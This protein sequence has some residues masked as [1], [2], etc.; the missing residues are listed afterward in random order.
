[1]VGVVDERLVAQSCLLRSRPHEDQAR[2]VER[3]CGRL[4]DGHP[5]NDDARVARRAAALALRQGR[6]SGG[7]RI[8]RTNCGRGTRHLARSKRCRSVCRV[9]HRIAHA[10]DS[11]VSSCV[12][13]R[14]SS[15]AKSMHVDET[16]D[17][18]RK[19]DSCPRFNLP[20]FWHPAAH[21]LSSRA[22]FR[23]P[24]GV[25]FVLRWKPAAFVEPIPPSSTPPFQACRSRS[26]PAM[27]LRAASARSAT[28]WRVGQRANASRLVGSEVTVA[29]RPLPRG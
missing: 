4:R 19:E 26:W 22:S 9:L 27:K 11:S 5:P 28:A 23:C 8:A 18:T 14:G 3:G 7:E 2:R 10:F 16:P 17:P 20:R 25:R 1:M 24:V 21:S 13:P 6:N 29:L 15:S 12:A